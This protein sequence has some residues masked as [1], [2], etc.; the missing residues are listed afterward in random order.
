MTAKQIVARV[1]LLDVVATM[2]LAC[3]L[4]VPACARQAELGSIGDGPAS[5]LW[6]GTFEPGNLSEWTA[7][8][9][10]GSYT[11]NTSAKPSATLA[12]AHNGHYAGL[13][14]IAPTASMMSTGYLFRNQPSPPQGYYS[15]WFYVPSTIDRRALAEP[16]AFQRQRN[17]RW[18][19]PRRDLGRESL[20]ASRQG[21]WRR[22]STT[23]PAPVSTCGRSPPS[24]SRSIPG[25]NSRCTCQKRPDRRVRSPC[26]KTAFRSFSGRTLRPSPTTGCSGTPGALRTPAVFR[27]RLRLHGRR[28]DQSGP[29]RARFLTRRPSGPGRKGAGRGDGRRDDLVRRCPHEVKVFCVR[30]HVLFRTACVP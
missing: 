12:M 1:R 26:G 4:A 14:T 19:E 29:R 9:E 27:L 23:T 17:W 18:Q 8:G 11:Q 28:R 21:D 7:D 2:L 24:P 13:F 30:T 10:G 6:R 25:C 20:P 5:V 22:S 3:L 15:A 16:L